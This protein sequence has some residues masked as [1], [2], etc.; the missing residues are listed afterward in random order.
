MRG[1]RL[2]SGGPGLEAG[3]AGSSPSGG[4]PGSVPEGG[5]QGSCLA[6]HPA[7][8]PE[9]AGG[10]PSLRVHGCHP[11]PALTPRPGSP[12][13]DE[14]GVHCA[15]LPPSGTGLHLVG[16]SRLASAKPP[17]GLGLL[18]PGTGGW[19][20][21]DSGWT[22]QPP[23][24]FSLSRLSQTRRLWPGLGSPLCSGLACASPRI[25]ELGV[26]Q[27]PG[28]TWSLTTD[29]G[30]PQAGVKGMGRSRVQSGLGLYFPGA[31]ASV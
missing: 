19:G 23:C 18:P 10:L 24:H 7:F 14:A 5:H 31:H 22:T 8:N 2:G 13:G 15:W 3:E 30:S 28:L 4:A 20:R 26:P 11:L 29:A 1:D 9:E 25:E 6:S 17:G 12:T 16:T 27:A 21:E